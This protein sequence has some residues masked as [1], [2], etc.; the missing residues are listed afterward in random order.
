MQF[1]HRESFLLRKVTVTL[2][3]I[4]ALQVLQCSLRIGKISRHPNLQPRTKICIKIPHKK[5]PPAQKF[6]VIFPRGVACG[7]CDTRAISLEPN[8]PFREPSVDAGE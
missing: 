8:P 3:E 5:T 1:A 7:V 2:F 6:F 4:F